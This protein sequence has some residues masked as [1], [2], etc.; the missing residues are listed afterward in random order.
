MSR[1]AWEFVLLELRRAR[2]SLSLLTGRRTAAY[3][4]ADGL[5]LFSL[6][7]DL[8]VGGGSPAEMYLQAV[9]LP[10]LILGVPVMADAVAVERRAGCLDLALA[11]PRADLYFV[12]RLAAA[13]ALMALQST[14]VLMVIWLGSTM[15]FALLYAVVQA[16]LVCALL[17]AL[18]LFWVLRL[19][20]AGAVILATYVSIAPFSKWFFSSPLPSIWDAKATGNFVLAPWDSLPWL[21]DCL[22][23]GLGA[24]A[25][26]L[27]ARRRLI[28]PEALLG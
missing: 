20:T 3:L 21:C 13:A 9:L 12:R 10:C 6:A 15:P 25:F 2:L 8:L 1:E 11:T 7:F 24:V 4:V 26:Y 23:L 27:Y 28:R 17:A 5:L 16:V 19:R 14:V 18:V 22:V